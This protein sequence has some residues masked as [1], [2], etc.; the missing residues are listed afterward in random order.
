[1][2]LATVGYQH[3]LLRYCAEGHNERFGVTK[4]AIR[5]NVTPEFKRAVAKVDEA[6]WHAL[7]CTVKGEVVATGHQYAEVC[8]VRQELS[9]K[10]HGPEY[11][12]VA[13]RTGSSL[14]R[15]R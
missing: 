3:E 6:Q 8:F 5:G 2:R 14:S 10:K 15:V 4:F 13:L 1:M 11:R 9:R 12:Y 7:R